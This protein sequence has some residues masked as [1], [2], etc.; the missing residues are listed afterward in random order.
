MRIRTRWSPMLII[1]PMV[2]L[3]LSL[4]LWGRDYNNYVA[5]QQ[6]RASPSK[7]SSELSD[8]LNVPVVSAAPLHGFHHGRAITCFTHPRVT[9]CYRLLKERG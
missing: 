6:V 5:D 1:L 3:G 8:T 9:L 7:T 4:V 2:A